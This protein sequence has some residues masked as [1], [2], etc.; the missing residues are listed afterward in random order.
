MVT[1][2]VSVSLNSAPMAAI[3][4]LMSNLPLKETAILLYAMYRYSGVVT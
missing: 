2:V 1:I 3:G 4:E